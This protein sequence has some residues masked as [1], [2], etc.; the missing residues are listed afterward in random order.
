ML[1]V[2]SSCPRRGL[3]RGYLMILTIGSKSL[4][5]SEIQ[6][7]LSRRSRCS[8]RPLL[9]QGEVKNSAAPGYTKLQGT[10]RPEK[11]CRASRAN[12]PA[13]RNGGQDEDNGPT[14]TSTL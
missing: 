8:R 9:G 2:P 4:R 12:L 5:A 13:Q 1:S 11:S 3:G 10:R 7:D 14:V 6:T